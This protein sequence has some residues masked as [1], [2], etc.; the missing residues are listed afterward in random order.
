MI[1]G[2]FLSIKKHPIEVIING[3]LHL[4]QLFCNVTA[5]LILRDSQHQGKLCSQKLFGVTQEIFITQMEFSAGFRLMLLMNV[6]RMNHAK[7][8]FSVSAV[9]HLSVALLPLSFICKSITARHTGGIQHGLQ[10]FRR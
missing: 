5:D 7:K 10:F 9:N 8:N 3:V 6:Q 2:V 4:F 1:D